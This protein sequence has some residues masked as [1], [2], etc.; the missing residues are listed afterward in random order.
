MLERPELRAALGHFWSGFGWHQEV[1]RPSAYVIM[2]RDPVEQIVSPFHYLQ[3]KNSTPFV[4]GEA[5]RGF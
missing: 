1:A 3:L 5:L 4:R 2:L